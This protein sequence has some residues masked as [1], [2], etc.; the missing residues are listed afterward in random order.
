MAKKENISVNKSTFIVNNFKKFFSRNRLLVII[1][2]IAVVLSILSPAFLSITNIFNVLWS[3]SVVGT[4]AVGMTFVIL[5]AGIDLSVGSIVC[6]T[7]VA[8][9]LLFDPLGL[10]LPFTL[11]LVLLLGAVLGLINGMLVTKARITPFIVTLATMAFYRGITLFMTQGKTIGVLKPESFL[12]LGGGKFLGIPISLIIFAFISI[13]GWFLAERTT[14]GRSVY[15]LGGNKIA[16]RMSGIKVKRV[17][18][19]AYIL[20][21]ICAAIAG[22][23]LTSLVQQAG[24][25][26]GRGYELDVIAA[27]V[28]GGTSLFGGVGTISGS[29]LGAILMGIIANGLN[30]LNVASPYHPVV[31]G[32]VIIFAVGV[33]IA[34]RRKSK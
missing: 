3:I 34:G 6:I 29:V 9:A 31:K 12:V 17:E 30:L 23:L 25:Y 28:A 15:L 4:M 13:L 2:V 20:S 5:T 10:S 19:N 22:I 1:L 16:A 11:F 7:G 27:V 32:I 8:C 21:G 18:M 26:Q 14:Y 33:E 24:S